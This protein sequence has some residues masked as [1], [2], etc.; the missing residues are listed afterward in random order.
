MTEGIFPKE[1]GNIYFARDANLTYGISEELEQLNISVGSTN[2]TGSYSGT[3]KRHFLHNRGSVSVYVNFD[4][5]AT[6]NSFEIKPNQRIE[7]F[8]ISQQINAITASGSSTLHVLGMEQ[9]TATTSMTGTSLSVTTTSDS[10]AT[11]GAAYV[12]LNN[13]GGNNVY[14]GFNATATTDMF[15]LAPSASLVI[16]VSSIGA[17]HAITSGGTSRLN[18]IYSTTL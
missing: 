9:I 1:N 5:A 3:M 2:S 11:T 13:S 14:V 18:V 12:F 6:T 10:V 8:G 17:V 4:S 7:V 16:P 15:E